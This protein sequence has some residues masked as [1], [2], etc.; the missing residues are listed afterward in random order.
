MIQIIVVRAHEIRPSPSIMIMTDPLAH[1]YPYTPHYCEENVWQAL[2]HPDF[3]AQLTN[4]HA[5]FISNTVRQCPIWEQRASRIYGNPVVW[6]YHVVML[7]TRPENPTQVWDFDTLLGA[8]SSFEQWWHTS[9][10]FLTQLTRPYLPLFRI[11]PARDY[12]TLLSS[13]R[14]HMRDEQGEWRMP[15]PPW[16]AIFHGTHNLS[17]LIDMSLEH[18]GEVLD[19]EA[20]HQRFQSRGDIR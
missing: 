5:V 12:I 3:Q 9:F 13:D 19:H 20:F 18:P 2:T 17:E 4:T 7:V 8:P 1:A 14:R 6:D 11:I 15:P 10:P 16:P